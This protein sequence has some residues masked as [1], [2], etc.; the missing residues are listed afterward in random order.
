MNKGILKQ[1]YKDY[2]AIWLWIFS[3]LFLLWLWYWLIDF[4]TLKLTFNAGYATIHII[5]HMLISILF[6]FLVTLRTYKIRNQHI[7]YKKKVNFLSAV[8]WAFW[9]I[10]TWCPV[11]GGWT[12]ISIFWLTNILARL[13]WYGLELKL[14]SVFLLFWSVDSIISNIQS[15]QIFSFWLWIKRKTILGSIGILLLSIIWIRYLM[16]PENFIKLPGEI[17]LIPG[18]DYITFPYELDNWCSNNLF[19]V[20]FLPKKQKDTTIVWVYTYNIE[21]LEKF[22]SCKYE[23][24][25]QEL[26]INDFQ[27]IV[28]QYSKSD[29]TSKNINK[30][31]YLVEYKNCKDEA[32]SHCIEWQYRLVKD[33]F[34]HKIVV[35]WA[36]WTKISDQEL[37]L[38]VDTEMSK[39]QLK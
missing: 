20:E 31:K 15:C 25:Q 3:L 32:I 29:A 17:L 6:S 23:W 19:F 26:S 21:T 12:L 24:L 35:R 4:E 14:L 34:A 16:T 39:I 11:C 9:I 22:E 28:T 33:E 13:P 30:M 10:I 18:S 8:W 36:L 38:L 2:I 7:Q 1:I 27:K 37:I 5:L